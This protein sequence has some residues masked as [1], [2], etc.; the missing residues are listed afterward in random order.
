MRL[1]YYDVEMATAWPFGCVIV[2]RD[3]IA[4]LTKL[5]KQRDTDILV[6]VHGD[7]I[8]FDYGAYR[9]VC[10][11]TKEFPPVQDFIKL[12]VDYCAAFSSKAL[13]QDVEYVTLG[14]KD[15]PVNIKA[16][17]RQ[18]EVTSD[19]DLRKRMLNCAIDS[20]KELEFT[21]YAY[22]LTSVLKL[23]GKLVDIYQLAGIDYTYKINSP[24]KNFTYI[25]RSFEQRK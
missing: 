5:K 3:A 9:M 10:G 12:C 16:K 22:Q 15:V 1:M 17:Q 20:D 13:L 11:V 23:C 25:I 2:P 8:L 24:D 6:K 21:V 18:A 7:Y 14:K 4:W 19:D